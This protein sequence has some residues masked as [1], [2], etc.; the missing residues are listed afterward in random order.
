MVKKVNNKVTI[1][2][3][4]DESD[5]LLLLEEFLETNKFKTICSNDPK[6]AL[7][8]VENN[9][10]DLVIA[11]L[12][13]PEM[14]GIE[15]TKEILRVNSELPIII[16]T[17]YASI[18]SAVESIKAGASDFITKPFKFNHTLF[19]INKALETKRLSKL[20]KKSSYY[21]K[22]SNIDELT[23]IFNLRYLKNYFTEQITE[24]N[25]L[26]NML[27]FMMADIDD[28]KNVNDKF[29]HQTGDLVLKNIAIILKKSVR[30]CDFLARYGG[31]EFAIILPETERET[32]LKVGERIL[33]EISGFKF[34]SKS[35][36]NIGKV[37]ITIGLATYP[38]DGKSYTKLIESADRALYKGKSEG[39]NRICTLDK[40]Y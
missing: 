39:K 19:V 9:E 7:E 1:L 32:A 36:E 23:R 8:I 26:N 15:L 28:F 2:I 18:E 11:D 12:K 4:D 31:E 37:T 25:R 30:T 16:M 17:G 34:K 24:H 35:G 3:V 21:K 14:D 29:G 27:S 33:S 38:I 5:I 20:A 22:L 6:N 13:M 40:Y 10:I